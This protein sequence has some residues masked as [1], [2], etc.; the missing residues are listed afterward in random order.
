M[1]RPTSRA[2]EWRLAKGESQTQHANVGSRVDAASNAVVAPIER[3]TGR[4]DGTFF[5]RLPTVNMTSPTG[6]ACKNSVWHWPQ[7]A[8]APAR[9][10]ARRCSAT[11]TTS[12]CSC[13]PSET[14][15][16]AR[17]VES[18]GVL[19]GKARGGGRLNNE[20]VTVARLAP[21]KRDELAARSRNGVC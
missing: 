15:S 12:C 4:G 10:C 3:P 18:E 14:N 16:P 17:R 6:Q 5:H 8:I 11:A 2:S 9:P 21:A 19:F 13:H 20:A 7:S 1:T